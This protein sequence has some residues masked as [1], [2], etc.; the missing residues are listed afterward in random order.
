MI[1][2]LTSG[3]GGTGKSCIAAY[4]GVAFA[5]MNHR[6]LIVEMGAQARAQDV[7]LGTENNLLFDYY[8]VVS[9]GAEVKN[10][11]V[12]TNYHEN[13]FLLPAPPLP[14][15]YLP[16]LDWYRSFLDYVGEVF[17]II[18][19]DGVDFHSFPPELSDLILQV[20]T[21]DTLAIRSASLHTAALY[22]A[23]VE[24]IRLIIN[25]VSNQVVPVSG[26][27]DFDD[28]IDKVG[29]QLIGVIPESPMLKYASNNS[30]ELEKDSLTKQVFENLA[31]RISGEQHLLLVK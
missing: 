15:T 18:I 3:K 8:D 14:F 29:V 25:Q 30:R 21:P 13:L 22:D 20:V 2:T 11:I 23:G 4:I 17:D 10:A 1:I 6:V 26:V 28:I 19:I 27:R 12:K 5:E 7:I 9:G 24:N 16:K 31:K